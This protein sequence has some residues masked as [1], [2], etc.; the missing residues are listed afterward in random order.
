MMAAMSEETGHGAASLSEGHN[1]NG[2]NLAD[3]AENSG[4]VA[5]EANASRETGLT[6][7]S[8]GGR[9]EQSELNA[10]SPSNESGNHRINASTSP[11]APQDDECD[12]SCL[13]AGLQE[14][15]IDP[16]PPN[17]ESGG[18]ELHSFESCRLQEPSNNDLDPSSP[19]DAAEKNELA[20]LTPDRG[21]G[22]DGF[23]A[24]DEFEDT[25]LDAVP[26]NEA[27]DKHDLNASS[28]GPESEKTDQ[29][30]SDLGDRS[31]ESVLDNSPLSDENSKPKSAP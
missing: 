18:N 5:E 9:P 19:A 1:Q 29:D 31:H 12:A 15:K 27:I 22:K 14:I 8:L 23:D 10:T 28:L 2:L 25:E 26:S 21:A 3:G 7:V 20:T 6:E 11:N 30:A 16:L 17:D 13:S 24:D 4:L